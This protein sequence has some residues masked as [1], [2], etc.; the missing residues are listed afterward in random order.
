MSRKCLTFWP[1]TR[2]TR[3]GKKLALDRSTYLGLAGSAPIK[4]K[5]NFSSFTV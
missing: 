3:C 5:I 1:V 4:K 2:I